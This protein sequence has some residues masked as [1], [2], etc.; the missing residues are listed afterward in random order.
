MTKR[1]SKVVQGE[2]PFPELE[3]L[4]GARKGSGPKRKSEE[5]RVSHHGRGDH[6]EARG[7][8]SLSLG[9]GGSGCGWR[10]S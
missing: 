2:L 8:E 5:P 7:Q 1:K 4:G 9:C 3:K 10:G 6:D